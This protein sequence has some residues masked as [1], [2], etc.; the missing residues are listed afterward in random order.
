[1]PDDAHAELANRFD[2][3]VRAEVNRLKG[4]YNPT[5]FLAMISEHGSVGATKRLLVDPRH[6]SYGFQRLWEMNKLDSSVEFAAC[7]P[8]FRPLFTD[9]ELREAEQRLIAHNFP[10]PQR[11]AE[12]ASRPPAWYQ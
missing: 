11:L 4:R 9:H 12:E 8:W 1:M 3:H 2:A 5:Q 10:L 6:T 7:L